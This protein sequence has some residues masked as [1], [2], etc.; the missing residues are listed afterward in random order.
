MLPG[1]LNSV[2]V[3]AAY[4][5]AYVI[6]DVVSYIHPVAPYAITPWNPPPGLSLALLLAFGLRYAPALF[7]AA[8]LAELLV[9]GGGAG[10]PEIAF[11]AFILA[12]GYTTI[13]A[14]LVKVMR[15]DAR[16][17]SMRD[18]L[19]FTVGVAAGTLAVSALYVGAHVVAGRFSW[20]DFADHALHFWVGDVIGV[21]VTT[22]FLL[23]HARRPLIR[24][25]PTMEAVLQALAIVAVLATVFSMAHVAAAKFFYLL[26]LPLIWICVRH[27]FP[28][29]TAG[30]LATQIGL[31][32]SVH[33]AGY[34]TESVVEFQL[35]MLALAITGAFLG[36]AVSQWRRASQAL[37]AREADLN[38]A[39]R[40]AAA[41]ETAS[42]LAHELNQ[43][44]TA[45]SNYV[46]A[47]DIMLREI[48]QT[49]PALSDTMRKALT[50]VERAGEVVRRL[51][52]FYRGGE[53]HR[54]PVEL[55]RLIDESMRPLRGR[56][57]RH[58]I[59][60]TQRLAPDLPTVAVDRVQIEMAIHNLLGN[61]IDA[62]SD[63]N[64]D[65]R[66]IVVEAAREGS[67][68][69]LAVHDS[70][71]GVAPAVAEQLF[72]TFA[73]SKPSGMGLGLAISRSIV[74]SHGGRLWLEPA[75]RGARFVLTLPVAR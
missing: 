38:R 46:Q 25:G 51:R 47:C 14:V 36:M 66:E 30:L 43:P 15:F 2:L 64:T 17:A 61:A 55:A 70:G 35:L 18:L 75:A 3:S 69:S 48:A 11:Y 7:V 39:M 12:A 23:V 50:E 8:L 34:A 72:R 26:F 13:A 16:F 40:V 54:E 5:A 33:L 49:P 52:D 74:E 59:V 42:A 71:P 62:I 41:A 44:L 6:L 4:V 57:E 53:A 73:T 1:L 45:A 9:R 29:A 60:V 68:V 22:P 63:A 20:S 24:Q 10:M 32:V 56:F 28:G 19:V 67:V 27:G 58:G 31:I 37:E 21:V 65:V